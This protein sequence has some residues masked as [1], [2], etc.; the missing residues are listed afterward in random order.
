MTELVGLMSSNQGSAYFI[1]EI[2]YFD[3]GYA[4][5]NL[6]GVRYLLSAIELPEPFELVLDG[7][8]KV[9]LNPDALERAFLAKDAKVIED[10]D[11]RLAYLGSPEFDPHTAV[12]ES[13]LD[14]LPA[15][16]LGQGTAQITSAKDTHL[17]IKCDLDAPGIL[18]LADAYDEG[19]RATVDGEPAVILRVDHGLRG[20]VLPAGEHTVTFGYE[21]ISL[22][23]GVSLGALGLLALVGLLLL[24]EPNPSTRQQPPALF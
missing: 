2:E 22:V 14:G 12:L 18:V 15:G 13:P 10:K 3:Q 11:T 19:W 17:S 4:V 21:P 6:L 1:K 24:R 5:G 7:P 16:P 8:T 23:I 9:Y 20:V